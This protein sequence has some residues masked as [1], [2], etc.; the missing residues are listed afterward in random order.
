MGLG[1][2]LAPANFQLRTEGDQVGTGKALLGPE[3]M[4]LDYGTIPLG[5][6]ETLFGAVEV[7]CGTVEMLLATENALLGT[8]EAQ[9]DTLESQLG[10]VK[11]P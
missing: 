5:I 8:V 2:D 4:Y 11:F 10:A 1:I 9:L 7:E 6:V 3:E